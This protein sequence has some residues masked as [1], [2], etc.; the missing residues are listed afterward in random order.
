MTAHDSIG[1]SSFAPQSSS[2]P[3]PVFERDVAG[4]GRL[5]LRPMRFPDDIAV[6]HPWVHDARARYWGLT[7]HA[8]AEVAAAYD[9]IR[10]RAD[11][12]IGLRDGQPA[13][14]VETYDPARDA[15]AA[16]YDVQPG[17]RGMH[18]LVAP[19]TGDAI[20]GYTWAVFS[21]VVAFVFADPAVRRM[22]VEPD[23]RNRAI[24]AL[25]RRAGFHYQRA[26]QLPNKTGHL[27]FLTRADHEATLARE[28]ATPGAPRVM[29]PDEPRWLAHG[30]AHLAPAAWDGA[31][32]ALIRKAIGELAHEALLQPRLIE[33]TD[34]APKPGAWRRYALTAGSAEYRFRARRLALDTWDVERGS[35]TKTLDGAAA[36][37][38]AML[39]MIELAP[40]IGLSPTM[41]PVYLEEIASTLHGAAFRRAHQVWTAGDLVHAEFQDIETAMTEG[42]PAFIA[43]SG[44]VGYDAS[45]YRAYA[46]ETGAPLRLVW[47]A[48]RRARA[49][50]ST[51]PG[52]SYDALMR[53]ELGDA[54]LAAFRA[55]LTAKGLAPDDY[56]FV[57]VHPWQWDNKLQTVFAPDLAARDLVFLG[58]SADVY[59]AQQ[60]IRTLFNTSAPARCYVKMSLSILNMGFMRGLSAEYMRNTPAINAWVDD[61]LRRDPFFARVGFS[62]LREVAAGGYRNPFFEA[63]TPK[64]HGYRKMLAA[65]WR[66]SPVPM[67]A[68]GQRLMTMAALLHRDRDGVA[69]APQL[70]R[71]SGLA[72][73]AWLDRYLGVYLMPLLHCLYAHDLAF[74]PHGEN[75]ILVLEDHVPVRALLK[76]IGEEVAVMDATRELPEAVARIR[77]DVP[78]HMR[79]LSIFTDVFDNFLRYLAQILVEQADYPEDQ[80]WRRVARCIA[81]YRDEHPE[82]AAKLARDDLFAPTFARSCLNRLQLANNTQMLDLS[83]PAAG[84]KLAG[85]LDNPVAAFAQEVAR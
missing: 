38:D 15:V 74:M 46:P 21:T 81:V 39:F 69:L 34:D 5:A 10:T 70:I 68:A 50:I 47:L 52:L 45:D 14:L 23:I 28:A 33:N 43:N 63:T 79:T 22:V 16:C 9:D 77:I 6:I 48:A 13:F 61:E 58:R 20:A 76:D 3:S 64:G 36:P 84:L 7:G 11:V 82:L 26:I 17:D 18:I 80:F 59:R 71:A 65:L 42:H 35:I 60:S 30:D 51:V 1:A 8:H 41:L 25:N 44:R 4:I 62:I 78:Q 32:E 24:H 19:A 72:T 57:P 12:F 53:D 54:T 55:Q 29:Q 67:L 40:Q 2:S 49:E 37:L 85:T 75:I 31:V 83:D 27:A 66:E 56:L 73:D